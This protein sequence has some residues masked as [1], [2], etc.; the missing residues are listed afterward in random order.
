MSALNEAVEALRQATDR[1]VQRLAAATMEEL[2]A[3]VEER[4]RL[5][6]VIR[7]ATAM[8]A[9]SEIAALKPVVDAILMKDV[10][11][12]RRMTALRDEAAGKLNQTAQVKVQRTAYEP[13]QL[14]D[15]Y[16]FDRKK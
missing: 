6:E 11:V 13:S 16:F 4:E 7:S 9:A 12:T 1:V 8:T 10:L 14:T 5:V 15:S 2:S 3:F